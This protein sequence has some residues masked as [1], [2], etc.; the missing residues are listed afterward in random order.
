MDALGIRRAAQRRLGYE[1]GIP[2]KEVPLQDFCYLTRIHYQ[3]VGDDIWGEHEIDYVLFLQVNKIT[4]DPNPDEISEIQWISRENI[5]DFVNNIGSPLTPWFKL[6]LNHQLP[7]WWSNL[8]SLYKFQDHASIH[9][10]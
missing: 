6:I 4:L 8:H 3:A 5:T 7:L 1:L 2:S 9:R 10:F